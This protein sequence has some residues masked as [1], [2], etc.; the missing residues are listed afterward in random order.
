MVRV[1]EARLLDV[2][3]VHRLKMLGE[4][5]SP[6]LRLPSRERTAI[7]YRAF[8][9]RVPYENLSNNRAIQE[10]PADAES[11]PRA[12]DRLLREN[13]SLGMGGTSFSL[14]YALRDLFRGVGVAA[15][16]TLGYNLVTEQAHAA[17]LVYVDDGPLLYDPSLLMAGPLP[18]R[19]GGTFDDPLGRFVMTARC[20]PTLTVSLRKT[21]A[22][23]DDAMSTPPAEPSDMSMS[24]AAWD[25]S[26]LLGDR[27][28]YSIIPVP[29][30][31]QNF[32]QAWLASFFRGRLMPLRLARRVGD[33]IYRYGQR[34]G[35]LEALRIGGREELDLGRDPPK[36][37]HKTFGICESCIR[38][39][40]DS[41]LGT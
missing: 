28:V 6:L 15:H 35:T 32:R 16:C 26:S 36:T 9:D 33:T 7:V 24:S 3:T 10:D 25:I 31:P 38:E 19:P 30:P 17:V 40:F 2:I 37:L 14:A 12:T 29:A 21:P 20:G 39:W 34:P 5:P 13:V 18:V 23:P 4:D 8:L 22:E 27:P 41:K 11:W 1:W